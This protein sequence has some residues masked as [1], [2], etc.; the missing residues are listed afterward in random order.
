[1]PALPEQDGELLDAYS[2]AV[3]GVARRVS[4]SVV[5]IESTR[6][7]ERHPEGSGSGF[8]FTPDGHILTN[9]HVVHGARRLEVTLSDGRRVSGHLVG[10]DPSTDLAVVRLYEASELVPVS[11]GDSS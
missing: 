6:R 9:S 11:F 8:L 5:K 1:M 3:V 10:D 2:Q 7:P 4:P